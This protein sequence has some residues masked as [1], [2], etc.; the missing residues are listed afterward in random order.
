MAHLYVVYLLVGSYNGWYVPV[1]QV[2]KCMPYL[3]S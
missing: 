1:Q 3:S 2:D